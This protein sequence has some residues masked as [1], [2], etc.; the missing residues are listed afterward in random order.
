MEVF[1]SAIVGV[2]AGLMSGFF[3][4]GGGTVV[5]TRVPCQ[6]V[7]LGVPAKGKRPVGD[8]CRQVKGRPVLLQL[9]DM[10]IAYAIV[11]LAAAMYGGRRQ[12]PGRNRRRDRTPSACPAPMN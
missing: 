6:M 12:H 4:V 2:L 10:P 7:S 3:G 1:V 8:G 5:A 11:G 9:G